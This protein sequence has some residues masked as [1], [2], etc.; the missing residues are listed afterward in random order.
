MYYLFEKQDSL[1]TPV[2]CFVFDAADEVFPIKPHWHYFAEFIF[3]MQGSI[4]VTADD[5]SYTVREGE[6]I[7]LHPSAVHSIF[8]GDGRLPVYAV[9]KFDPLKFPSHNSYAPSP[10]DIFRFARERDM[11]IYFGAEQASE[12]GCRGIFEECVREMKNYLYGV[13]IVLRSDIYRLIFGVVRV[14][15]DSGLDINSCP[16]SRDSYGIENITEFID[17]HLDE[18]IKV[19]DIAEKCHLSYSNFAAKFHELYAM[20]CK[21]YIERMRIFRAE[22][23]LLFTDFDL[24]YISQQTGFS[25]CSH[26]IRSFKKYRGTTPKQFRLGRRK[27]ASQS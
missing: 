16:V 15:I 25:D 12:L 26:F 24:N 14:W 22:E 4:L 8:S 20:S 10:A 9:I 5:K 1:N 19:S 23:L 2:E 27:K 17:L 7:I 6:F 13:D 21:E 18:N 3:V 11:Q